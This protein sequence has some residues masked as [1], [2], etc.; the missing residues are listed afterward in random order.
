ML[1][2]YNEDVPPPD[3]DGYVQVTSIEEEPDV[4]FPQVMQM[5]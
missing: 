1:K 4:F 5:T 3:E 2:P